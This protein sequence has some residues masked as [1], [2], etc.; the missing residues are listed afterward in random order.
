MNTNKKI[1][2]EL[3][4]L[5]RYG[6]EREYIKESISVLELIQ[7]E[8]EFYEY[9][10]IFTKFANEQ[11]KKELDFLTFY[12]RNNIRNTYDVVIELSYDKINRKRRGIIL[13]YADNVFDIKK[14]YNLKKEELKHIEKNIELYKELAFLGEQQSVYKLEIPSVSNQFSINLYNNYLE[15][16]SPKYKELDTYLYLNYNYN[17]EQ[18]RNNYEKYNETLL[19]DLCLGNKKIYETEKGFIEFYTNNYGIRR[20]LTKKDCENIIHLLDSIHIYKEILPSRITKS[21]E[22]KKVLSK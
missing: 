15:L 12:Y 14:E 5:I 3:T 8:K 13:T 21:N 18:S 20:L 9:L 2:E 16:T 19:D 1:K 4:K 7:K 10:K 17:Q 6:E 11:M 22:K